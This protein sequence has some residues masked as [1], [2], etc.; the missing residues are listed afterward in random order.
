MSQRHDNPTALASDTDTAAEA[1]GPWRALAISL[2]IAVAYVLAAWGGELVAPTSVYPAPL[3]PAA[4]VAFA[5]L[6]VFG[7]RNWPGVWLGA[8]VLALGRGDFAADGLL[9]SLLPALLLASG[10]AAQAALGAALTRRQLAVPSPRATPQLVLRFL[11]LAGPM[12]CVVSAGVVVAATAAFG[13]RFAGLPNGEVWL[14]LWVGDSLGVALFAPLLLLAWPRMA[15]TWGW[16]RWHMLLPLGITIAA[17]V[18][19]NAVVQ[20]MT[21]NVDHARRQA[22]AK[23]AAHAMQTAITASVE[24]LR[25]IQ[26]LFAAS[27][28][29]TRAEFVRFAEPLVHGSVIEGMGWAPRVPHEKLVAF[30]VQARQATGRDDYRVFEPDSASRPRAP[31]A[32]AE[33]FP[34]LYGVPAARHQ[35]VLGLDLGFELADR[36]AQEAPLRDLD[37]FGLTALTTRLTGERELIYYLPHF[38]GGFD[39]RKADL[40]ARRTALAGYIVGVID[41]VT[42]F[43]DRLAAAKASGFALR[44]TL[45]QSDGTLLPLV[46]TIPPG[47]VAQ[48][49]TD[50]ADQQFPLRVEMVDLRAPADPY[51][52]YPVAALLLG[53]FVSALALMAANVTSE[54]QQMKAGLIESE[55]R[56]RLLFENI[57]AGFVL[58]EVVRDDHG[59]PADLVVLAANKEFAKAT[60]LNLQDAIGKRL[61]ELLPGIENDAADWIGNYGEIALGGE[62]RQFEQGS[63]LLGTHYAVAAYQPEPN[64]CAVTFSDITARKRAELL[65]SRLSHVLESITGERG[66]AEILEELVRVIEAYAKGVR[67]TVLLHDAAGKR[68]R[69]GSAPSFPEDFIVA[70][71]GIPVGPG[72]GACGSA[73]YTKQLVIVEDIQTDPLMQDY[74]EIAARHDLRAVWSQ[75]I[76]NSDGTVLG[77]FALYYA[78]PRK[79]TADELELISLA[80]HVAGIAI[81]RRQAD[82]TL[83]KLNAELESRVATRTAE[84]QQ[85]HMA[86]IARE[87]EIRTILDHVVDS[88]ITI[89][90]AGIIRS[91]NPATE[92]LFGYRQAELLG[93]NV[94]MLMPEPHA[95]AHDEYLAHYLRTGEKKIIGIGRTVEGRHKD[96]RAI[97]LDLAIGE[98]SLNGKRFFTGIVRDVGE[99]T[100]IMAELE[101]AKQAADAANQAKSAFLAT[102]S[103]EIRTPM[104]GVLGMLE[105]LEHSS[106]SEHQRDQVQTM[107]D[108]AATLLALIDDILDFSKIEAGRIELERAPLGLADLVEGLCTSQLSDARRRGVALRVFVDPELPTHVL[109][110]DTRLRQVLYNLIGNA[111]KFSSGN[112][113]RAGRVAVRVRFAARE[114]LRITFTVED[115]GIGMDAAAQACLFTPFTQAEASTTRRFGGTGL[116]L[117]ICKRLVDLMGGTIS[118]DSKPGAGSVFAVTLPF[119]PAPEQA[120]RPHYGLSGLV[121]FLLDDADIDGD[122]LAHYLEHAGATV[123]RSSDAAQVR[124]LAAAGDTSTPSVLIHGET[125]SRRWR[126]GDLPAHL[127]RVQVGHG[128][129][130]RARLDAPDCISI[131]GDALR[132]GAFLRTVAVAAGRASPEIVE[133]RS[134]DT[135]PGETVPP[136]TVAQARD[137]NRLILVAEDDSVNQKVILQQLALLGHAAEVANDGVEALARWNEGGFALLL[138]DLHMPLM[139]GYQ[140]AAE[141]RRRESGGRHAPIVVLTAN[142]LRDE[143]NRAKAAGIDDYLIKPVRLAR[144]REVLDAWLP[145]TPASTASDVPSPAQTADA[146]A[147]ALDVAVLR[148]LVG[149][150]PAILSELLAEYAHSIA[151]AVPELRSA[152]AAKDHEQTAAI[153][154]RLKSSSRSVGALPLGDLCVELE[155]AGKRNDGPAVE[156]CM[157]RFETLLAEVEHELAL[158]SGE[159]GT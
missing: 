80:A 21:D 72:A 60:G 125:E 62:A 18:A 142:A 155:N 20:R 74:R 3:W 157:A 14:R 76:V 7:L 113:V 61:T 91:V 45:I 112:P 81:E 89:D 152:V 41:P 46:D 88:I 154:H 151:R 33:H 102:M 139:D 105:V 27:E 93:R 51:P 95:S 143:A 4:G 54:R 156:H 35:G 58:F 83:R 120:L 138:T 135:L 145:P 97:S 90:A 122:T 100:R 132:R 128:R 119:E 31:A 44:A 149:D 108:S 114:P 1:G 36:I 118:V 25:S 158:L 24:R 110:D 5:A 12:S 57:N 26:R 82:E 53:L 38:R 52:L 63:E 133:Q 50:I 39:T 123:R 30:E 85:S 28:R 115:N 65:Q 99:R 47:R 130:R 86:L 73:T 71:D 68:L 79:P 9:P 131:D 140:L 37:G 96:G 22:V 55:E 116:G 146:P 29:V 147:P 8:L 148:R 66:L 15:A 107:R 19:A 32:R 101:A 94:S 159:K 129:R 117:S 126:D 2:C 137:E 141:I 153:A 121:C 13:G 127:R 106:L 87:Q 11:L 49:R 40:Q 104:N 109:G 67:A 136:P 43:T 134:T 150:A 144:L 64:R 48:W 111:I 103:H 124:Q 98:F 92:S 59:A 23:D 34:L 84:L 56:Y 42:L 75:P 70:V 10:V 77:T 78:Q 69:H 17:L 6:I 16:A